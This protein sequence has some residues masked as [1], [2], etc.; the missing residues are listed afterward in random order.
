MSRHAIVI[1]D[2][3]DDYRP[4]VAPR[5]RKRPAQADYVTVD[6]VSSDEEAPA[7]KPKRRRKKAVAVA[8][9]DDEEFRWVAAGRSWAVCSAVSPGLWSLVPELSP[10]WRHLLLQSDP[11]CHV[12]L[13]K[14]L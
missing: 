11:S 3:D 6:L 9:H 8:D 12:P 1:D 13:S 10:P 14:V 2:D 5:Q 4:H 7:P